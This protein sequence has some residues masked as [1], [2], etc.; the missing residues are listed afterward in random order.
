[1]ERTFLNDNYCVDRL[2]KEWIKHKEIILAVDFDNT[3]Y[4]YHKRV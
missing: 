4:D 1:M 2:Y 3:L